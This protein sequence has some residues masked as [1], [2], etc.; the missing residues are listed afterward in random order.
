MLDAMR[1]GALNWGARILL[2]LLAFAFVVWGMGPWLRGYGSDVEAM[3]R[4]VKKRF[5]HMGDVTARM[6]LSAVG[7]IEYG[8]WKPTVRQRVGRP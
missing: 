4:A 7:A 8:S 6:F 2:G 1:K 5:S 3:T